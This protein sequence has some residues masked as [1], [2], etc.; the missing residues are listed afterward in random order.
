M[1]WCKTA[2]SP[3]RQ[4]NGDTA[5]LHQAIDSLRIKHRK[6]IVASF[7]YDYD[8]CLGDQTKSHTTRDAFWFKATVIP[9]IISNGYRHLYKLVAC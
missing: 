6:S 2:L 5:V 4:S 9:F 8:C 3:V 1:A 7:H